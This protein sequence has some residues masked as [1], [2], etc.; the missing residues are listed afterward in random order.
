MLPAQFIVEAAFKSAQG[1]VLMS[2]DR[3]CRRL[4]FGR[5]RLDVVLEGVVVDVI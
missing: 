5:V 2:R 1:G 4:V 3:N